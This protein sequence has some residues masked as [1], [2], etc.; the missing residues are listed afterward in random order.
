M[1]LRFLHIFLL[2]LLL[3][4]VSLA[5]TT[6]STTASGIKEGWSSWVIERHDDYDCPWE[7]STKTEKACVWP[8]KLTLSLVQKGLDFSYDIEVFS[9]EARVALP[10][11]NLH[12]P[13]NVRALAKSITVIESGNKPYVILAKGKHTLSGQFGWQR[14]PGFLTVPQSIAFVD[15][16]KAGKLLTVNRQNN[17]VIFS[18]VNGDAVKT[19]RESIKVKVYRKL[20]DSIPMF[21]ET[22]L[23]LSV[24]GKPREIQ[25]G[26]LVWDDSEVTSVTSNMPTRIE[27]NGHIRLQLTAGEHE[28]VIQTRFKIP[29]STLMMQKVSDDWPNVEYISFQ[30]NSNI[31]QVKITGAMSVDTSQIDLPYEYANLPTYKLTPSTSLIITTLVRGDD[32]PA[33]NLLKISRN[34]WLAFDGQSITAQDVIEGSMNSGWRLDASKDTTIGRA[35]VD[36]QPVLITDYNGKQ[37]LEIRSPKINLNAVTSVQDSSSLFATGWEAKADSYNATLHLPPGWRVM[38]VGGIE[39]VSGTWIEKWDLWDIFILLIVT[40][41]TRRLFNNKAAVLAF[42]TV[43]TS[44]HEPS[45]PLL[46]IPFLLA[47][48]ALLSVSSGKFKSFLKG[49]AIL[50]SVSFIVVMISFAVASFRLAIYPSLEKSQLSHY[51]Q[52]RN[53]RY[54]APMMNSNQD[55]SSHSVET[56][57]TKF[58]QSSELEEIAIL[59]SRAKQRSLYQVTEN[60]R[61]QTGPGLPTW[62]WN[63]VKLR[64]KS[65]VLPD[66][67]L[68]ITYCPPALTGLWRVT[69]VFLIGFFGLLVML[70]LLPHLKPSKSST[71]DDEPASNSSIASVMAITLVLGMSSMLPATSAVAEAY[72]SEALLKELE[73]K[74]TKAPICLPNCLSLDNGRLTIKGKKLALTFTAYAQSNVTMH[75]PVLAGELKRS[76]IMLNGETSFTARQSRG[77][78]SMLLTKGH[79][80]IAL[81]GMLTGDNAS[82]TLPHAIHNFKVSSKGWL[83][84]GLVDGRVLNKTLS[85]QS[86]SN[87]VNTKKDTLVLDPIAAIVNINRTLILDKEWVIKTSIKRIAPSKGPISVSIPLLQGEKVLNNNFSIANDHIAIQ[88]KHSQNVV[89]WQSAIDP[90]DNIILEAGISDSYVETWRVQPSS[91]WRLE[92]SGIPTVKEDNAVSSLEPFWMPWPGEKLD[93]RISRPEGVK[94]ATHTIESAKLKYTSGERVQKSKLSLAVRASMGEEY[95]FALPEKAEILKID[96]DG[97]SLNI[98]NAES[99]TIP[100]KPGLQNIV[101]D[102]QQQN[103]VGWSDTTPLIK[104]PSDLTN[105]EISFSLPYDRWPLYFN[106]PAIGPAMLYW[107]ILAVIIICSFAL[108]YGMKKARLN[109][110]VTIIGWLLLGIGLSTVNR[111]GLLIT[112]AF[113]ALM[114]YRKDYVNPLAM[115]RNQFNLLQVFL[116]VV[117]F[118]AAISILSAIP[119]GLLSNPDM[120]VIGN[121]SYSHLYNFYQDKAAAG[122]FPTA[123]VISL[124]MLGYRLIM[125]LWSLWLASRIISWSGWGWQ[126]FSSKAVW[127]SKP[128]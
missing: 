9:K 33:T 123:T 49:W 124:P 81:N 70:K 56:K 21:L 44:Y 19:K 90:V 53:Q 116:V 92:Y 102:F 73:A 69:N 77:K 46:I 108:F 41:A 127:V 61:V 100:L 91:L 118:F 111:Y 43:V 8:G 72:P 82:I 26:Q 105:I 63:T 65:P 32:S 16:Q 86:T 79:H 85:L 119:M 50:L 84:G 71:H 57:R 125:M 96:V 120:K 113:F 42:I 4:W 97:K 126:A 20:I 66:Q 3:P 52:H 99:I 74:I 28:L 110:P 24:S 12:W 27:K 31:R 62:V 55:A 1:F 5:S 106:G 38:N 48:L 128:K 25:L 88:L 34:L 78:R 30:A 15:L 36:G 29:P 37:G 101:V 54:G 39:S 58:Q 89:S 6:P 11:S 23:E 95:T 67:Q 114:A 117:T 10:G 64:S 59:G 17:R 60:D 51:S 40:A 18:K 47:L 115:K 121:G 7:A 109:V 104:L 103:T 76:V 22:R 2:T 14:K 13:T 87:S 83:V 35:T 122:E 45:S 98:P 93:V 112:I 80:K 68:S 107:G 75:L 94:G